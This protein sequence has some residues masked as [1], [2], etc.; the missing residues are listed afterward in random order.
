MVQDKGEDLDHLSVTARPLEQP[1]LQLPEGIG[2]FQKRCTVAQGAGLALNDSQ[3]VTP[4]INRAPRFLVG[5]LND[6]PVFAQDLPFR[7]HDKPFRVYAQADG[8]IGKG[9]RHTVTVALEGDQAGGRH[10]LGLLDETIEGAANR[11]QTA[12]LLGV[13]IG[14]GAG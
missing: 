3:I 5:P 11:H 2:H 7:H 8:P 12:H 9:S 6:P 10:A 1:S 14:D 4:V 13:H